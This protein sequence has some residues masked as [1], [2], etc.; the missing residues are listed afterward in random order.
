MN[1]EYCIWVVIEIG[2]FEKAPLSIF[3]KNRG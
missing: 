3:D 2:N 1:E